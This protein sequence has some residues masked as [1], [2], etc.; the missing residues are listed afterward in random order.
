MQL[1]MTAGSCNVDFEPHMWEWLGL[2]SVT[3]AHIN[4][5]GALR[6]LLF[7]T[8]YLLHTPKLL[9]VGELV[10]NQESQIEGGDL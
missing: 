6:G 5:W 7:Q 4:L 10:V 3:S 1:E 8:E 9:C 2:D